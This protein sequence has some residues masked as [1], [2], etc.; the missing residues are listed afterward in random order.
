MAPTAALDP[1]A[2]LHQDAVEGVKL[3]GPPNQRLCF[4]DDG[5]APFPT[6]HK[7]DVGAAA[8][9]GN[10]QILPRHPYRARKEY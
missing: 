4:F 5:Y 8:N 9:S 10:S 6:I 1:S 2:D 3:G 7:T